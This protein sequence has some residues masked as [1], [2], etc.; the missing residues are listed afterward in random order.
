[1]SDNQKFFAG[2]ILGAAAGA[3]VTLFLQSDKGK[4]LVSKVK[5]KA[6][7]VSDDLKSRVDDVDHK[8]TDL[9]DKG[10]QF[11]NDLKEKAREANA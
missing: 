10:K 7:D 8:V 5:E 4:D 3:I 1:M 9:I 11:V 6:G 2:L